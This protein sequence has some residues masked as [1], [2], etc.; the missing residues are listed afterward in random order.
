CTLYSE[1]QHYVQ[2]GVA[3]LFDQ[4][5]CLA[6]FNDDEQL[7]QAGDTVCSLQLPPSLYRFC[8]SPLSFVQLSWERGRSRPAI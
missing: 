1:L 3:A 8:P 6:A 7:C 4:I 5:V 2:S